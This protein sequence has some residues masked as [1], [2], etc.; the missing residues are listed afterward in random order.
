MTDLA[1][2]KH[3]LS[4]RESEMDETISVNVESPAAKLFD[5]VLPEA[6][7]VSDDVL[8]QGKS[9]RRFI[10]AALN[11]AEHLRH[12]ERSYHEQGEPENHIWHDVR[13]IL[14][15]SE[16][17]SDAAG[18]V[19]NAPASVSDDTHGPQNLHERSGE[20]VEVPM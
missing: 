10:L 4:E 2:L 8:V 19:R 11:V 15:W 18:P 5:E 1:K 12:T 17:S 7:R 13:C 20:M 3:G 9:L 6:N 14:E 16:P